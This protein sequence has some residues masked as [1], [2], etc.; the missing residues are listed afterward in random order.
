MKSKGRSLAGQSFTLAMATAIAQILY[1]V[2]TTMVV[3]QSA[4]HE[5]GTI[6]IALGS[7]GFLAGLMDFGF[8][9][10]SIRELAAQRM[11]VAQYWQKL[12]T[13]LGFVI[14]IGAAVVLAGTLL[15][16][17]ELGG[18][19]AAVALG[20]SVV[21]GVNV[22]SS[23]RQ[24]FRRVSNVIMAERAVSLILFLLVFFILGVPA[25]ESFWISTCLGSATASLLG[26]SFAYRDGDLPRRLSGSHPWK[27][28]AGY[29]TFSL[30]ISAGMLDVALLGLYGGGSQAG[31]YGAVAR[32]TQPVMLLSQAFS[33]AIAPTVGRA[34]TS[35]AAFEVVR[36][37]FW[38]PSLGVIACATMVILSPIAVP[39]L[40]GPEYIDSGQVLVVL[41]IGAAVVLVNQPLATFMQARGY[42]RLVGV[43]AAATVALHLGLVAL[44]A[45]SFGAVGT[46]ISY[47]VSQVTLTVILTVA[48]VIMA[49]D[50]RP[51]FLLRH[52]QLPAIGGSPLSTE[53]GRSPTVGSCSAGPKTLPRT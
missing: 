45:K 1:V 21:T 48:A 4:P 17:P 6:A 34:S 26:L 28:V 7:G 51:R 53:D 52:D 41:T 18:A 42:D 15:S 36:P 46:A 44:T 9:S 14:A 47:T 24:D 12:A 39:L 22:P 11:E 5:F 32:W 16:G 13:K 27:G 37:F 50:K 43:A 30:A 25:V 2:L 19:I 38:V 49:S 29:S 10:L 23:A 8:T 35:R 40:I 31:L 20:R 33:A 3:S